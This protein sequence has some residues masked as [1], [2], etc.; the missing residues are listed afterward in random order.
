MGSDP[1]MLTVLS[2]TTDKLFFKRLPS[3]KLLAAFFTLIP[4]EK[5]ST[6]SWDDQIFA[7]EGRNLVFRLETAP[8]ATQRPQAPILGPLNMIYRSAES[9]FQLGREYNMTSLH[10]CDTLSHMILTCGTVTT[11]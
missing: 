1:K 2:V 10:D 9:A 3:L 8:Q 5:I 11:M 4:K 6:M 7:E